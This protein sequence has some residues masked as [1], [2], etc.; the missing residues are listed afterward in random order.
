VQ[1]SRGWMV[2]PGILAVLEVV[3]ALNGK[4]TKMVV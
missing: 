1:V 2:A 4:V 3:M